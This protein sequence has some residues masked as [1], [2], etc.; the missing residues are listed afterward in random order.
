VAG[1]EAGTSIGIGYVGESYI[2]FGPVGMFTPI[3]L[4]G[5]LYG[6]INRFFITRTRYKLLG[7]AFAVS[8][9][10]FSAYEIETSNIKLVGGVIAAALVSIVIYKAFAGTI[11]RVLQKSPM[12]LNVRQR[13]LPPLR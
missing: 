3:F 6:V 5:L 10:I 2:D 8:I 11:M 4:L 1:A 12:P 9:L 7:S 13:S